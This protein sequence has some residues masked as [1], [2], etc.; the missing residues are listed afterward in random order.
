M[1]LSPLT[2]ELHH[3]LIN[4][5]LSDNDL[6]RVRSFVNQQADLRVRNKNG[7]NAFTLAIKSNQLDILNYFRELD[8]NY[9]NSQV[10][11]MQARWII[12]KEQ[13]G[14]FTA[15]ELD[16]TQMDQ[17]EKN[18]NITFPKTE[19]IEIGKIMSQSIGKREGKAA[20][21]YL[22][23]EALNFSLQHLREILGARFYAYFSGEQG[24][25]MAKTRLV[26]M[27]KDELLEEK[28]VHMK[29]NESFEEASLSDESLIFRYIEEEEDIINL[30]SRMLS[31]TQYNSNKP[32]ITEDG[33]ISIDIDGIKQEVQGYLSTMMV[34]KFIQDFDCDG[35]GYNDGYA[36]TSAGI[37][38]VK[39]DSG[40]AFGFMDDIHVDITDI[41][42]GIAINLTYQM[43]GNVEYRTFI[44]LEY[45]DLNNCSQLREE[46]K[47]I[48]ALLRQYYPEFD[49][50][51][52]VLGSITYAEIL[53]HPKL[54]HELAKTIYNI[55]NCSEENLTH[56]VTYNIPPQI[57][58][59]RLEEDQE[60]IVNSLKLRQ[61]AMARI[62]S[63][64]IEYMKLYESF[65]G[66]EDL[67]NF[68]AIFEIMRSS[69]AK[70]QQTGYEPL[71]NNLLLD[72]AKLGYEV[73]EVSKKL[74]YNAK[75]AAQD[76]RQESINVQNV[77]NTI[78]ILEYFS[79]IQS[80]ANSFVK[81]LQLKSSQC[82][83]FSSFAEKIRNEVKNAASIDFK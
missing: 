70:Q 47:P 22:L 58:H 9:F 10:R 6:G 25:I 24:T 29:K 16:R 82:Y 49:P 30:G 20:T 66:H 55:V 3:L 38:N 63:K 62:Y 69:N 48:S 42:E 11:V 51:D 50:S 44:P 18:L 43:L 7:D 72:S 52:P 77:E 60:T 41:S 79:T 12:G 14:I 21:S 76:S 36:L 83:T 67:A 61:Q 26:T 15:S 8:I 73:Y 5:H 74:M 45:I 39:I 75:C 46:L 71:D 33:K 4:I 40:R 37:Q 35:F 27:I 80:T 17:G 68:D 32:Y 57:N 59:L 34:A 31:F 2:Q 28:S 53:K 78:K 56:L 64:E 65:E 19:G 23:K 54:Y 1:P 81:N 13:D